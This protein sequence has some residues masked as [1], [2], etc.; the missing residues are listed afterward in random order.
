VPVEA[1]SSTASTTNCGDH[2]ATL[3]NEECSTCLCEAERNVTAVDTQSNHNETVV[4]GHEA[5]T[6]NEN[7]IANQVCQPNDVKMEVLFSF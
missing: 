1:S 2:N 3:S 6:V 7:G 4:N 5:H